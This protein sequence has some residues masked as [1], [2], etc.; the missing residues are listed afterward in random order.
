MASAIKLKTLL[1]L[2]LSPRHGSIDTVLVVERDT[3]GGVIAYVLFLGLMVG[4]AIALF[5]GLRLVKLI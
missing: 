5:F 1:P 3:M 2:P 4:T